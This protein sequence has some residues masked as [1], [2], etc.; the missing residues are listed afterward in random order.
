MQGFDLNTELVLSHIHSPSPVLLSNH[1]V[2]KQ[3]HYKIVVWVV[4]SSTLA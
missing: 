1:L 3:K 4:L 2:D